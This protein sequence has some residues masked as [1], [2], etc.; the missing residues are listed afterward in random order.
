M[1]DFISFI[2]NGISKS[3]LLKMLQRQRQEGKTEI[4]SLVFYQDGQLL[5]R[6]GI[7]PYTTVQ[8]GQL[9]SL[10]KSFAATAIGIACDLGLLHAEDRVIDLFPD[11]A[12][13]DPDPN[14][15]ALTVH[16][17]LSMNTGHE[18]CTMSQI[19]ASDDGVSAFFNCPLTHR[20]G[21]HFVYNTGATYMLSA[22][23]TRLTGETL[24]DFLYERLFYPLGIRPAQWQQSGGALSEGGV[25]LFL[26]CDDIAKLG[27]LYLNQ[28]VYQGKRLLSAEWVRTAQS[29]HSDTTGNGTADWSCG[30][31]YQLWRNARG[32]YRADGAMGQYCLILPE[33]NLVLAV[34]SESKD[35]Q[36][37]LDLLFEYLADFRSADNEAAVDLSAAL[38]SFYPPAQYQG[39]AV[40]SKYDGLYR[41][42]PNLQGFTKVSLQSAKTQICLD[43]T[44]GVRRQSVIAGNG[45]WIENRITAP[46]WKPTLIGLAPYLRAEESIFLASCRMESDGKLC[47]D[48]RYTNCPHKGTYTIALQDGNLTISLSHFAGTLYPEA[49]E[50]TGQRIL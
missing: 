35:M 15:E 30:Y 9:Y 5:A 13:A 2:Q 43:F 19:A 4:H 7:P 27:L 22:I 44:D 48:V 45:V 33:Q 24:F 10:S 23:I 18:A 37:A 40:P 34:L 6:V 47:I 25:G 12:P 41:L 42:N 14:W 16:H 26:S 29:A 50:L 31:G 8:Q 1:E 3:K 49:A 46:A 36:L 17:L 39:E 28:G 11:K 21:T 20:P 38:R 32:G